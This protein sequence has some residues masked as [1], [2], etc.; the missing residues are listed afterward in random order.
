LAP[1]S[2]HGI[3]REL[4]RRLRSAGRADLAEAALDRVGLT[5]DGSTIYVHIWMRPHWRHYRG[6]DVYPLA[7]ADHPDL[8]TLAQWRGFLHEARLLLHDDFNRIVQW[9][10]GR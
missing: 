8:R 9:F 10:D 7:F 5:D 6:G 4:R 1:V 2:V 3:E